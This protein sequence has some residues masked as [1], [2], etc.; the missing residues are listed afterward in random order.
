MAWT[1]EY[2]LRPYH[3]RSMC[4][5]PNPTFCRSTDGRLLDFKEG[6]PDAIQ[7]ETDEFKKALQELELP[8]GTILALMPGHEERSTNEGRPLARV[9]LAIAESD[10]RYVPMVD[11]LIRT[12]SILR[13]ST[14]AERSFVATVRSMRV[15]NPQSVKGTVVAVL[16]DTVTTGTSVAAAR[17]LLLEAGATRVAAVA[18]ARTVKYF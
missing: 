9:V 13:R 12:K 14:S 16:D 6:R 7:A 4:G 2:C 11:A 17:A 10:H 3:P 18:L 5:E 8:P 15:T 1:A